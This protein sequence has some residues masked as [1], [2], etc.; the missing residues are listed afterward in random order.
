MVL[1]FF[2][3]DVFKKPRTLQKVAERLFQNGQYVFLRCKIN[4][5]LCHFFERSIVSIFRLNF[6][7]NSIK[8]E[9]N[10]NLFRKGYHLTQ[11]AVCWWFLM[12]QSPSGQIKFFRFLVFFFHSH[13]SCPLALLPASRGLTALAAFRCGCG[14]P[15]LRAG[16]NSKWEPVRRRDSA[17]GLSQR[18]VVDYQNLEVDFPPK[19]DFPPFFCCWFSTKIST[20]KCNHPAGPCRGK[21]PDIQ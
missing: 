8:K 12:F 1:T 9:E 18:F 4:S 7:T 14:A 11:I 21:R 19:F 20:G 10:A 15:E 3:C 16:A 6:P 2:R 17:D 13:L 5:Q